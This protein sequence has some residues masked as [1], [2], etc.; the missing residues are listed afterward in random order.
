MLTKP[1]L[2]FSWEIYLLI[3]YLFLLSLLPF[4]KM[5]DDQFSIFSHVDCIFYMNLLMLVN[6]LTCSLSRVVMKV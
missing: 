4:Q 5:P 1:P 3:S 6:N 2:F